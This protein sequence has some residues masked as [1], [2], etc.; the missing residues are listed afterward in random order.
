M[1]KPIEIENIEEMRLRAGID[2]VELRQEIR[3]LRIGDLVKLTLMT[4]AKSCVGETVFVR[5]TSIKGN[6][7]RGKL[8]QRPASAGPSK[9]RVG[10][11]V[12]FTTAHIHSLPK[13]QPAHGR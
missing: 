4:G 10:L 2:D 11:A 3:G 5:I 13:E 9:L 8:A 6:E 7:F 1:R 12:A